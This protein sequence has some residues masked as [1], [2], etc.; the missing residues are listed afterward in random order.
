[1]KI[2]QKWESQLP[3]PTGSSSIAAREGRALAKDPAPHPSI[4]KH[5]YKLTYKHTYKLTYK[6]TQAN[7]HKH[8]YKTKQTHTYKNKADAPPKQ[9]PKKQT[10]KNTL[11]YNLYSSKYC[12]RVVLHRKFYDM[13]C[14]IFL[15]HLDLTCLSEG[16]KTAPAS[17]CNSNGGYLFYLFLLDISI[18]WMA[19]LCR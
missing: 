15:P 1:M 19:P 17:L 16:V 11:P 4:H 10:S 3:Y 13:F 18:N 8:T 5:T 6:H 2:L 12:I 7:T 9:H 14:C